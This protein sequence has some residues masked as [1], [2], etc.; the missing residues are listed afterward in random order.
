MHIVRYKL[1]NIQ[2]VE[3]KLYHDFNPNVKAFPLLTKADIIEC[4]RKWCKK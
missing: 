2:D 1:M 3:Y 4:F